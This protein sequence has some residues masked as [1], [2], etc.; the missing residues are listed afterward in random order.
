MRNLLT[1]F[2]VLAAM[3]I[4]PASAQYRNYESQPN[5]T[6]GYTGTIGNQNFDVDIGNGEVSGQV[7]GQRPGTITQR[8]SATPGN[9]GATQRRCYVDGYGN[10][11][12][13]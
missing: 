9:I 5:A 1:T 3:M 2:L 7:G 13:Q 8:K 12:C 10:A 11:Y 4:G 6:G